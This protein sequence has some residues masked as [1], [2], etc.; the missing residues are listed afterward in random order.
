VAPRTFGTKA[1]VL[2]VLGVL[3]ALGGAALWLSDHDRRDRYQRTARVWR[4]TARRGTHWLVVKGRGVRASEERRAELE[5]RFAIRSAEDVARELGNMKGAIMKAGQMLSFIADGLPPEAQ[6][7]LATLQADVPPMAPSLAAQVVREELG[8]DPERLFLD[9]DPVPV[10]AASIGQVHRAVMRDGRIVAVKV[11][12][13]GVDR[14]I[15]SDLD[16]AELLYGLFSAMALRNLDVRA[17]VDELRMRM[18]DELDYLKEA[19]NQSQM[20]AIY[21]GHPFISVPAVVPEHSARR[22]LTS[23][24]ADG[25]RWDEFLRTASSAEHQRAA[26]VVFRFSQGS[27]H[28]H[29]VFNGDPHPGN[30]RFH[31]DG[32]VTF[33][34]FGLVKRWEPGEWERLVPV[35]DHLLEEDRAGTVAAMVDAGFLPPD[36]GLDPDVVWGY[37]SGPYQPYLTEEFTFSRAWTSSVLGQLLDVNG[38]YA[39]VLRK[40]NL[41]PSFVILDR[42]VWGTSAILGRMGATNRWRAILAEYREGGP[43]A[44][45]LGLEEAAWRDRTGRA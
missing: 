44:T 45:T 26:E 35:L 33:L 36:H 29:G 18:G 43:P 25:M 37:V 3:G 32:R 27:V 14:A 40:L 17:V 42:V 24:W 6:A 10:A 12:Y 5:E 34:D 22:V 28:A 8:D 11:Q 2:P 20:A 41:P 21:E 1:V 13:P 7:A 30:Y 23:E 19:A 16:N 4:L 31:P 39:E 38:P 9:W 15:R